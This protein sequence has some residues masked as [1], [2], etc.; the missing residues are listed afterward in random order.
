MTIASG[1]P[2]A[3][4]VDFLPIRKI[5]PYKRRYYLIWAVCYLPKWFPFAG[6]LRFAEKAKAYRNKFVEDQY[7]YSWKSKVKLS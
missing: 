4:I 1:P 6:F 3:T 5:P 2:G 7:D